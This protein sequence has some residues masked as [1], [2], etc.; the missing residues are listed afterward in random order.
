M[1]AWFFRKFR[2]DFEEDKYQ[3]HVRVRC[4]GKLYSMFIKVKISYTKT[5]RTQVMF[6]RPWRYYC[7]RYG[8]VVGDR[9]TFKRWAMASYEVSVQKGSNIQVEVG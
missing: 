3:G 2:E 5:G 6:T 8:F 4:M 7:A 9:V 1:P